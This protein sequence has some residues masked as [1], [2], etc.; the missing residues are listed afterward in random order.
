MVWQMISAVL[1]NFCSIKTY[2]RKVIW[3]FKRGCTNTD[4]AFV[5]PNSAVVAEN[6]L[7]MHKMVLIDRKLKF[8]EIIEIPG[9]SMFTFLNKQLPIK[10]FVPIRLVDQK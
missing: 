6:I 2:N 4:V 1:F 5:G 10:S 3:C 7:K 8:H 9:G